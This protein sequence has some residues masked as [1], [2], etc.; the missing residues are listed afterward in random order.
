MAV[1]SDFLGVAEKF[2][3]RLLRDDLGDWFEIYTEFGGAVANDPNF[4][5]KIISRRQNVGVDDPET[6]QQ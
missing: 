6:N 4:L 5:S 3:P 2:V 1:V